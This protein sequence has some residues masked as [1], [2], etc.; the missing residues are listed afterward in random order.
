MNLFF[1]LSF[2]SDKDVSLGSKEGVSAAATLIF[3][4][5]RNKKEGNG[6]CSV[7][8]KPEEEE[9]KRQLAGCQNRRK[10][11]DCARSDS[12]RTHDI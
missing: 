4:R 1:H 10:K 8:L 2:P 7:A 5:K 11:W 3:S 6:I 12:I 9:E